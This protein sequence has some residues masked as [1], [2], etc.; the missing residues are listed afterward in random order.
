M[1]KIPKIKC[2]TTRSGKTVFQYPFSEQKVTEI[3]P[4]NLNFSDNDH[5]D[6]CAIFTYLESKEILYNRPD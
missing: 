6:A 3:H 4:F 1:T 5:L 2:G